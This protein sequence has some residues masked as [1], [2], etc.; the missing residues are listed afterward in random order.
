MGFRPDKEKCFL[1]ALKNRITEE[2]QLKLHFIN[3]DCDF[4]ARI[5]M[6]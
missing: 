5:L 2:K 4:S 6:I 1:A 3:A